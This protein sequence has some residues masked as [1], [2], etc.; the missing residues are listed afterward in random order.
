MFGRDPTLPIDN[1]LK[2]RRKYLGKEHHLITL[3]KSHESF[4]L[5]HRNLRKAKKCQAH[6]ANQGA[7]DIDYK[8]GD[9]IFLKNNTQT[10]KLASKYLLYYRS[11]KKTGPHN[12]EIRSQLGGDVVTVHSNNIRLAN[13]DKWIVP[14]SAEPKLTHRAQ[15]VIP[16][17]ESDTD[18]ECSSDC[19]VTIPEVSC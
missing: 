2:P 7:K 14:R 12:L 10:N 11:I 5:V 18:S 17:S 19:R 1:L 9:P 13:T 6:Y 8:V 16:P 3:E 4:M 15:Y